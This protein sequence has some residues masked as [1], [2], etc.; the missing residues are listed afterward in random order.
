MFEDRLINEADHRWFVDKQ[1][2]LTKQHFGLEMDDV[3]GGNRLIYADFLVPG[4]ATRRTAFVR[5]GSV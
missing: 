5:S 4:T 3:T 2:Q 1:K